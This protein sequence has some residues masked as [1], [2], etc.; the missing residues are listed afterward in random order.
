MIFHQIRIADPHV[1]AV[2]NPLKRFYWLVL[3]LQAVACRT[4]FGISVWLKTG[5][6]EEYMFSKYKSL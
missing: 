2:K 3:A 1:F 5:D 6:L 4:F